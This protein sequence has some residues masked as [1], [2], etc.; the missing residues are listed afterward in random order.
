MK[1]LL[2]FTVCAFI[3][4]GA[5]AQTKVNHNT[6]RSNKTTRGKIDLN[7]TLDKPTNFDNTNLEINERAFFNVI[8]KGYKISWKKSSQSNYTYSLKLIPIDTNEPSKI[9]NLFRNSKEGITKN[10]LRTNSFTITQKLKPNK[11]YALLVVKHPVGISFKEF[12]ATVDDD[13][14]HNYFTTWYYVSEG[15]VGELPGAIDGCSS[16]VCGSKCE[17]GLCPDGTIRKCGCSTGSCFAML[18]ASR[19]ELT[20]LNV[21]DESGI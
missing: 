5:M 15:G 13:S 19:S 6:T 11:Y 12:I 9:K 18:C 16:S 3:T 21:P 8:S 14:V 2:L 20:L 7:T 17:G 10:N 4:I 1:K